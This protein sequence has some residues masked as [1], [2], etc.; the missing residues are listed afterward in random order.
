MKK[1]ET[2]AKVLQ[3]L[4]EEG[5]LEEDEEGRILVVSG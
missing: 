2:V 5:I 3:F 4:T 1:Q